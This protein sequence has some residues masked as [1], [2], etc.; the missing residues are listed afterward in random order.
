MLAVNRTEIDVL[1]L[2]CQSQEIE[3]IVWKFINSDLEN[4]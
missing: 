2:G 4:Q 1:S 3:V